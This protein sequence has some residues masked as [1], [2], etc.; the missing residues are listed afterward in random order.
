ML[1]KLSSWHI[2]FSF[3]NQ[4]KFSSIF[5]VLSVQTSKRMTNQLSKI[6]FPEH[7]SLE[8]IWYSLETSRKKNTVFQSNFP[9]IFP[10]YTWID[11]LT[12]LHIFNCQATK[13]SLELQIWYKKQKFS[14]KRNDFPQ[15][16]SSRRPDGSCDKPENI[17][18]IKTP[19]I[20]SQSRKR[21]ETLSKVEIL[22]NISNIFLLT[23]F[24]GYV[25]YNFDN[26]GECFR[27]NWKK[28]PQNLEK[29][30]VSFSLLRNDFL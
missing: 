2:D 30:T 17:F 25:D 7:L 24:Q 18:W 23:V 5:R 16:I 28:L 9:E 29:E 20:L 4:S 26:F 22:C 6:I 21:F 13:K 1:C 8:H 19:I 15:K 10:L 12:H 3:D 27:W 14:G 11:T